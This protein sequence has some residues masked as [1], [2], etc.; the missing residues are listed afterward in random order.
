MISSHI[1]AC[2]QFLCPKCETLLFQKSIRVAFLLQLTWS[3]NFY[4]MLLGRL[5]QHAVN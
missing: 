2:A 4:S 3:I 1:D 5:L